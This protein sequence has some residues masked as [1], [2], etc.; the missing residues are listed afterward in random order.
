MEL[1]FFSNHHSILN[2]LGSFIRDTGRDEKEYKCNG[3]K[4]RQEDNTRIGLGEVV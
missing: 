1:V 4:P 3:K 2:I